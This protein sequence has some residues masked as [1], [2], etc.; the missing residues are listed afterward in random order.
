MSTSRLNIE[1]AECRR[2]AAEFAGKP[3]AAFLLRVASSFEELA[4]RPS[5][6]ITGSARNRL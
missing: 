6:L 2:Q 1:A 3:E 4:R 5:H